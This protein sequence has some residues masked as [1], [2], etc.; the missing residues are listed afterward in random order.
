MKSFASSLDIFKVY[1]RVCLCGKANFRYQKFILVFLKWILSRFYYKGLCSWPS[2]KR[3]DVNRKKLTVMPGNISFAVLRIS[4]IDF[5]PPFSAL[6]SH[7]TELVFQRRE[8]LVQNLMKIIFSK[9]IL[10]GNLSYTFTKF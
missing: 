6:E 1:I 10:I 7:N 5:R 8:P 2:S 9:N 4:V 3:P